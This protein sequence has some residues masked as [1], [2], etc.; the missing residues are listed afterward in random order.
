MKFISETIKKGFKME[1]NMMILM[2]LFFVC[3]KAIIILEAQEKESLEGVV[4]QNKQIKTDAINIKNR[5]AVVN[6]TTR[7]IT[8][9]EDRDQDYMTTKIY[10]IKHMK[11]VDLRPFV[12]GAVR[13]A[14]RES[15]VARLNY[16][17]GKKQFLSV[18]MPIF[19]VPYIDDMIAKL[20]LPGIKDNAGSVIAGTGIHHFYYK[21][22]IRS[23]NHML[24]AVIRDRFQG[25]DEAIFRD[26]QSNLFYWKGS[27]S[28]GKDIAKWLKALDRPLPQMEVRLKIYQISE[29]DLIELGIDWVAFKNGPGAELFGAGLDYLDFQSFSDV[30]S[31]SNMLD[32]SSLANITSP[33]MFV[34]PNIDLT[35]LRL[36]NQKGKARVATSAYLTIV[37]DQARATDA[38]GNSSTP[39]AFGNARYRIRFNPVFQAITKDNNEI[40]VETTQPG[41]TLYFSRPV[42]G[43]NNT[44]NPTEAAMLNVGWNLEI[45]N[46][47]S[48]Q[49]NTGDRIEDDYQ[50]ESHTTIGANSEK[51]LA[52]Y[53]KHHKVSQD[54]GI[55]FLGEIPGLKYIF[56]STADSMKKYRY[57]VTLEAKPIL[58]NR[59]WGEWAG[60]TVTA[61]E[62][63]KKYAES[64]EK[65]SLP[66]TNTQVEIPYLF[67]SK[68][69]IKKGGSK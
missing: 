5:E 32:I 53:I 47:M 49:T 8:L 11:A 35:F 46:A 55:P 25:G 7:K 67:G 17:F 28:D 15:T 45:D 44:K 62:M 63:L 52:T 60:K 27:E 64:N 36:L 69:K 43:H 54:N 14:D 1:R 26:G 51:L 40:A 2:L 13:R 57:Y 21:P 20:D 61:S 65:V 23:T 6:G 10:E 12:E 4:Q 37:N 38:F 68:T 24:E 59:S 18:S 3:F 56:G 48:E 19:M 22:N 9:L 30:S 42:I 66:P 39:G 58:R 16:K 33:G 29:D 34:A 41:I 31:L 50:F